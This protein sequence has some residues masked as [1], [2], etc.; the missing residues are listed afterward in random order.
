M[1]INLALMS[2]IDIPVPECQL[3][4]HQPTISEISFIGEEDVFVGVPTL[5]LNKTMFS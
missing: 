2:G 4:I 5:C 3:V 1:D